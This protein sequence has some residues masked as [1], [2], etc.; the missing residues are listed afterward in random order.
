MEENLQE[1]ALILEER[2]RVKY[3]EK[4][5]RG[6][7]GKRE[8]KRCVSDLFPENLSSLGFFR[9]LVGNGDG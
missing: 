1:I 2:K 5:N 3:A 9:E 8:G 4:L 7:E 6:K